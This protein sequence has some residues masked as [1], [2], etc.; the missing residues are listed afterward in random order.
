MILSSALNSDEF[1]LLV[2]RYIKTEEFET[3][4]KKLPSDL[5]ALCLEM[6]EM[7]KE[8]NLVKFCEFLE[9]Q[10]LSLSLPNLSFKKK[11]KKNF[12]HGQKFFLKS[13]VGSCSDEQE[14]LTIGISH[15]L[16][17]KFN[18]MIWPKAE[19]E[20]GKM[21]RLIILYQSLLVYVGKLE[22]EEKKV[23]DEGFEKVQ[24][25]E[26]AKEEIGKILKLAGL[27]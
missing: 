13:K 2:S 23:I 1:S 14:L 21:K 15:L 27:K 5:R 24:K 22:E 9:E 3:V 11:A 25:G 4:C 12:L 10:C 17:D 19:L 20:E 26:E 6:I 7:L 16:V 18:R 8:K